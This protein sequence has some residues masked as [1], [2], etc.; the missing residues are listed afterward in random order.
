M[1]NIH[2]IINRLNNKDLGI[3]LIRIAIGAVFVHAGWLKIQMMDAVVNGFTSS[4]IPAALAYF[5]TYVEL[6]GGAALILGVFVRYTGVLL[7][8]I[9][10]VAIGK[11]HISNGFGL[12]NGGYEYVFVLLLSSLA[13]VTLGAGAYSLGRLFKR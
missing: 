6:I 1:S 7:A 10:L 11:V 4:G 9:M 13:L 2:T 5:V 12:Q 8:I 3:L